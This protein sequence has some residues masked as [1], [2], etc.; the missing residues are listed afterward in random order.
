MELE[1]LLAADDGPSRRD[2]A[3]ADTISADAGRGDRLQGLQ[4][5][6]AQHLLEQSVEVEVGGP[7][8]LRVPEKPLHR[9]D[10]PQYAALQRGLDRAGAG[11]GSDTGGDDVGA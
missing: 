6:E 1:G 7:E 8:K 10:D 4:G 11:A 3:F 2:L 5:P 9:H